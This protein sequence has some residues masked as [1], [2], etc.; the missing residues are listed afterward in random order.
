MLPFSDLCRTRSSPPCGLPRIFRIIFIFFATTF[1]WGRILIRLFN[2]RGFFVAMTET[3]V[4]DCARRHQVPLHNGR[5]SPEAKWPHGSSAR[6]RGQNV[7][8]PD[9]CREHDH[10]SWTFRPHRAGQTRL[11]RWISHQDSEDHSL[12]VLLL[13]ATAHRFS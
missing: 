1:F 5:R 7:T 2:T 3:H 12:C 10:L 9:V 8:L 13:R 4:R 6:S 11:P